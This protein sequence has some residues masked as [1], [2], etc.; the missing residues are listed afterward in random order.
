[1]SNSGDSTIELELP[2]MVKVELLQLE[3]SNS[4]P[5]SSGFELK[6]SWYFPPPEIPNNLGESP[7]GLEANS[8][9]NR[10]DLCFFQST[11]ARSIHCPVRFVNPGIGILVSASMTVQLRCASCGIIA[12][13]KTGE[14]LPSSICS[15]EL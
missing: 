4:Q 9:F 14:Y 15:C 2:E 12:S 6:P 5:M 10:R 11:A 8:R 13:M 7:R 3:L 1:M